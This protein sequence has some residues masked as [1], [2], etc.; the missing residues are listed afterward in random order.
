[1]NEQ[2]WHSVTLNKE[3]CTGCTICMQNCP[4]QAIRIIDGKAKIIKE[5]CI[6]CGL[7]IKVCP[8]NAKSALTDTF[9]T[10][11]IFPYKVALTST[12]F[13]A[14]FSNKYSKGQ[15]HN[16][17]KELG[18][19]AIYDISSFAEVISVYLNDFIL[20]KKIQK[21]VVSTF[22]PAITRL[23]QLK[24]PELIKNIS[25]LESPIE[26]AGKFIRNKLQEE[27][28]Y[29]DCDIGIFLLSPCPAKITS[30]KAPIGL[31]KS[32]LNGALSVKEIFPSLLKKLLSDKEIKMNENHRCLGELWGRIGGQ[33]ELGNIEKSIKVDGIYEVAKILDMVDLGKLNGIDFIEAYSC[34]GGCVGG[35]LNVENPFIA[36]YRIE[37]NSLNCIPLKEEY[38][39]KNFTFEE[40][41]WNKEII[42]LNIM[43]L[44]HNINKALEKMKEIDR[45]FNELPRIDCGA[46]G[47]PSCRA[48]AE[49]IVLNRAEITDCIFKKLE[50]DSN[51]Y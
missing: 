15:L 5:K 41:C 23:I 19:D 1:M 7:C 26:V 21:P 6:D 10:I 24:N 44:D 17:I 39:R 42:P 43:I 40:L 12:S 13:Y 2:Y 4:T 11:N 38:I 8:N 34:I 18:F 20:T 47:S 27:S 33:S 3:L 36:K 46:C 16:A 28:K 51:E 29:D 45:I 30:I 50:G 49:D 37:S 32:S 22:C 48:L 14:Q 9:D 25:K 35:P 31:E